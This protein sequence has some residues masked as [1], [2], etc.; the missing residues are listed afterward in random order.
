MKKYTNLNSERIKW[1]STWNILLTYLQDLNVFYTKYKFLLINLK[2]SL[3]YIEKL[4]SGY[5]PFQWV[6][7]LFPLGGGTF[8]HPPLQNLKFRAL[9]GERDPW[10][11]LTFPKYTLG[12][13]WV[14]N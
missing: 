4:L 5:K 9:N 10:D 7:T 12:P 11:F 2:F 8:C 1:D 3:T 6:L 13:L 14:N